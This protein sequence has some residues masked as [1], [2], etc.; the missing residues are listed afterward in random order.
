MSYRDIT[1]FL[2]KTDN[3]EEIAAFFGKTEKQVNDV[4]FISPNN[5]EYQRVVICLSDALDAIL[6]IFVRGPE[7][8]VEYFDYL[9]PQVS[10]HFNIYDD[11]WQKLLY[12]IDHG[13]LSGII[14]E[15]PS[16]ATDPL[17]GYIKFCYGHTL[18]KM[19]DGVHLML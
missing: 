18:R 13:K 6:W 16:E 11:M 1:D 17:F 14:L 19:N 4:I 8:A 3:I 7:V 2:E 9:K 5:P 15:R 10:D 12:P